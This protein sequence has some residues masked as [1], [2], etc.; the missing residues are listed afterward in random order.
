MINESPRCRAARQRAETYMIFTHGARTHH[1]EQA[2]RG[3]FRRGYRHALAS[4]ITAIRAF[5][6]HKREHR[7]FLASM[8]FEVNVQALVTITGARR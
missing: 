5:P 4:A 2:A 6:P 1:A 7:A 3:M 8:I